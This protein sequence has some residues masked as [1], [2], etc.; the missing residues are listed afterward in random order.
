MNA[1][2][3][4]IAHIYYPEQGTTWEEYRRAYSGYVTY[5][6]KR[7]LEIFDANR[8]VDNG[9]G[10]IFVIHADEG[11]YPRRLE[12]APDMNMLDFTAEEIHEKFG[13]INALYWDAKRYGAPY[14]AETPI[15]NWRIILSKISGDDIPLIDN[16]RSMLMRSDDQV[17]DVRDV[18][19]AFAKPRLEAPAD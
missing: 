10:L 14:L 9:R 5:L 4:C 3:D 13:I 2:G 6:N 1:K 18:T 12:G 19:S 16:E 11:P 8:A 7:L 15:N 17:Y